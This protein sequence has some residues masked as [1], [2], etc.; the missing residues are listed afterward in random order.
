MEG[1]KIGTNFTI[2]LLFFGVAALEAFQGHN[3]TKAA[4]WVAISIVFL[5]ADRPR[6]HA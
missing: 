1:I 2:F 5:I 6:K 4:F 3:L